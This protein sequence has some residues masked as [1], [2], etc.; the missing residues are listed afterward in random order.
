MAFTILGLAVPCMYLSRY[1][2]FPQPDLQKA[3]EFSNYV[4]TTLQ[5]EKQQQKEQQLYLA[6]SLSVNMEIK[7]AESQFDQAEE[8]GKKCL[9]ITNKL[10]SRDDPFVQW[11]LHLFAIAMVGQQKFFL[12]EGLL[13]RLEQLIFNQSTNHENVV[14]QFQVETLNNYATVMEN[15]D[16]KQEAEQIKQKLEEYKEK[17]EIL[18]D[19][20]YHVKFEQLLYNVNLES[21]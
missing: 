6:R 18:S 9:E 5:K 7:I 12:A 3:S 21:E 1:F 8:Y 20:Y 10:Q 2:Y 4:Q 16:R 13:R 15:M 11:V 19:I 17:K 14:Y